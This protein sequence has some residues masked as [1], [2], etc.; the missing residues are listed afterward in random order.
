MRQSSQFGG[1][2]ILRLVSLLAIVALLLPAGVACTTATTGGDATKP[3]I[4]GGTLSLTGVWAETA[5][6]IQ[7]GYELWADDINKRGGLLGRQVELRILDDEA[8]PDKA[9]QILEK[10]LTVDK[11]DLLLGAYPATTIAAQA[12]VAEKYKYVYVGMGAHSPSFQQGYQYF[13]G[14]PPLMMDW[15]PLGFL[16]W[17]KE[18]RQQ[19][20]PPEKLETIAIISLN[21][22][23]G[24]SGRNGAKGFIEKNLADMKIVVDES[25]DSPLA[26]AEPLITK[27]KQAQADVLLLNSAP[28][29][30]TLLLRTLKVQGYQPKVIFSAIGAQSLDWVKEMG[31]L[32]DNTFTGFTGDANTARAKSVNEMSVAKFK[33]PAS[34]YMLAGYNYGAVLEAGVN[35]VK[36]LDNT[37]IR[38]WLKANEVDTALGKLRFNEKGLTQELSYAYQVQKDKVVLVY[39]KG[40]GAASAIYP[41]PRWK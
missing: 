7:M 21:N 29:E 37:K 11:V 39:P 24:Q 9:V 6:Q 3:I 2:T 14:G 35:G 27:V 5:K 40:A 36:S 25:Y 17:L 31:E 33:Q 13:F 20:N 34:L 4:V 22:V 1:R 32:A 16:A 28:A 30:T 41:I 23:I 12:P 38:D 15:Y 19:P 18:L 8:K 26:N 10:L